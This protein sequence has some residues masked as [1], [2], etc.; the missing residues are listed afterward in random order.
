MNEPTTTIH[1]LYFDGC[2]NVEQARRNIRAALSQVKANRDWK[3]LDLHSEK[4]PQH[5]RGFPSPTILVN[6]EEIE[7]GATSR[8]GSSSCRSAG[9]PSVEAIAKALDG[10]PMKS[11][12]ASLS[13]LPAALIG[14]LP[15]FA[16]PLCYPALA[17]L[18]SA[19]GVLG[20]SS[21]AALRP[22]MI[23]FL[24]LAVFGLLFQAR[25]SGRYAPLGLGIV[26]AIGIYL[27]M[28]VIGS[29]ELKVAS[30]ALL[31]GA[32]IW[33]VVP[34]FRAARILKGCPSCESEK[35]G[36]VDNG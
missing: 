6:G 1:L 32:S 23:A 29:F 11:W 17:G 33:N 36:G 18:L 9:A 20:I 27:A 21:T 5:W 4:T 3:E 30:I 10:A 26:A 35:E 16:C 22:V 28:F 25:K 19:L 2:P 12:L 8:A 31:L 13:V 24:A 34:M 15:A 7:S 14:A